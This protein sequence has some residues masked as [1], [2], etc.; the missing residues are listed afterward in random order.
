MR[1]ILAPAVQR[2]C[3]RSARLAI[4]S[5]MPCCQ[6]VS[7]A[8]HLRNSARRIDLGQEPSSMAAPVCCCPRYGYRSLVQ[9]LSWRSWGVA[10]PTRDGPPKV[11]NFHR[12]RKPHPRL[13]QRSRPIFFTEC[14]FC[15]GQRCHCLNLNS[16]NRHWRNSLQSILLC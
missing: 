2:R 1:N 10:M 13:Q 5:G 16:I 8:E 6:P 3:L 14:D 4:T 12:H 7:A 15:S 9:F 11:T